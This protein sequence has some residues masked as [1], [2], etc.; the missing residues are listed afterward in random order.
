MVYRANLAALLAIGTLWAALLV[1]SGAMIS[2]SSGAVLPGTR[3]PA[4]LFGMTIVAAGEYV[5]LVVVASRVFPKASGRL[6]AATELFV[7]GVMCVL[8]LAAVIAL[9]VGVTA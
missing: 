8:A 7:A 2:L 6:L 4:S 3:G 1:V 5:F 9:L